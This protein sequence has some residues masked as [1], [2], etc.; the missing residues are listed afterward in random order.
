MEASDVKIRIGAPVLGC[1]ANIL[2]IE[3]GG[4]GLDLLSR[5]YIPIIEM[6]TNSNSIK[7]W[8]Y[9]VP[10]AIFIDFVVVVLTKYAGKD[11]YFKVDALN[12]WYDKFGIFAI[13]SDV[14]SALIG[15]GASRYIYTA[16]K[17]KTPLYLFVILFLFQ[18][19]H[20]LFFYQAIILPIPEG[21]NKMI[22]VFKAYAKENGA[23]ILVAD[24]MILAST[25]I[26]AYYLSSIQSHY[27]VAGLIVT[28]YSFC[29]I[30]FTKLHN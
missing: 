12:D 3:N 15:I 17:L 24:Y 6:L 22:D 23:K 18:L 7:D 2:S 10:A 26:V 5:L 27:V 25:L 30:M 8:F 4:E 1:R 29:Y 14:T 11:P 28:L 16:L 20:D 13:I 21:E 9:I 19:F